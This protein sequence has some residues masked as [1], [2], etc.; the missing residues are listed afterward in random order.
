MLRVCYLH[1]SALWQKTGGKPQTR[2]CQLGPDCTSSACVVVPGI[3][4]TLQRKKL[5]PREVWEPAQGYLVAMKLGFLRHVRLTPKAVLLTPKAGKPPFP[6]RPH[7]TS[8]ENQTE[9][10]KATLL[11]QIVTKNENPLASVSDCNCSITQH[12]HRN[13]LC[14]SSLNKI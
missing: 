6:L 1:P 11:L 13:D 4:P 3:V 8:L 12:F 5:R 9:S 2:G 7:F 14:T 10:L